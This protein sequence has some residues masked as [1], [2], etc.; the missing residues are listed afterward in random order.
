MENAFFLGIG[1][2]FVIG[3]LLIATET[4]VKVH[5]ATVALLMGAVLWTILVMSPELF[6]DTAHSH[7]Y[8]SFSQI[9]QFLFFMWGAMIVVEIMSAHQSFEVISSCI[10]TQSKKGLIWLV[11]ILSF[12]VSAVLDNLTT[13]IIMVTIVQ[14]ICRDPEER[15]IVGASVVL[16]ANAGGAWTPIGDVTTTM[17]WIGGQISTS[18]VI[19]KLFLPSFFAFVVGSFLLSLYMKKSTSIHLSKTRPSKKSVAVC[20]LGCSLLILVPVFKVVTGL[21]PYMGMLFAASLLSVISDVIERGKH[22]DDRVTLYKE[23]KRIDYATILFLFGVLLSVSA[24]EAAGML[25]LLSQKLQS[26]FSRMEMVPV[27]IGFISAIIDNVPIV[28]ASMG[29][30]SLT[31]FPQ[32]HPFWL[33]TAYC[34]GVGGNMLIIGSAA[35]VAF[36]GLEKVDFLWYLKKIALIALVSYLL[37]VGI[38]LLFV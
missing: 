33:L 28:A 19:Q 38:F 29:M 15:K 34:A 13:T 16:A 6:T 36:M 12:F 25:H 30:Y 27:A 18:G 1:L 32:D 10:A 22:E 37:G 17:L 21:P 24:L 8:E 26:T 4:Y 5:R 9:C 2:V 31:E 20:A 35:G 3:Y 23:L 14:K 11:G 7:L